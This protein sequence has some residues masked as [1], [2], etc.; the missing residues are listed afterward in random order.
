MMMKESDIIFES[1]N[2]WIFD[3][4][5]KGF[6][7]Y[8]T[9]ITHSTRCAQIGWTGQVGLDRAKQEIKKRQ[10]IDDR[11]ILHRNH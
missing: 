2:Y 7:V 9:G 11:A 6:E 5:Q 8:K 1:G 4:K 3:A 10:E